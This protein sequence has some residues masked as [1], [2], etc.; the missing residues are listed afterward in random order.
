MNLIARTLFIL[1]T[2]TLAFNCYSQSQLTD[3][4][5]ND[6]KVLLLKDKWL[7]DNILGLDTNIKTYKLFK[8][9]SMMPFVGNHTEFLDSSTF[10]S[11]YFAWCGNDFFTD[12][13]GKF[14]FLDDNKIAITVETVYYSGEWAKPTEHRQTKYLAFKISINADTLQ[15]TK[16]N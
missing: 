7:T 9:D 1:V 13:S 4:R 12:V 16:Q 10:K 14:K 11:R 3:T 2:I 6:F 5:K 15:L 8:F